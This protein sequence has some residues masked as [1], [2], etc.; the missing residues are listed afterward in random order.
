MT[1]EEFIA[2]AMEILN[3]H[4]CGGGAVVCNTPDTVYL[5]AYSYMTRYQ[6]IGLS[7]NILKLEGYMIAEEAGG[8]ARP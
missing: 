2:K 3:D 5:G 7:K 8:K 4:G 6:L 1:D